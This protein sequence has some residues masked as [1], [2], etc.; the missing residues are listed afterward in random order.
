MSTRIGDWLNENTPGFDDPKKPENNRLLAKAET[1]YREEYFQ[2][3]VFWMHDIG[4]KQ[5]EETKLPGILS[6]TIAG[7][8]WEAY[9]NFRN[10]KTF[11]SVTGGIGVAATAVGFDPFGFVGDQI[12]G[13]ML[14]HVE[15]YRKQL[16]GLAGN[17]KMVQA[18]SDT[19]KKVAE[20]LTGM[21]TTWKSGVEADIATWT[22]S[23]GEAYRNR[24]TDL[25]DQI[26]GAG[27]IA[28]TLGEIMETVSKIV[29]AFRKM[30]QDI[31][32]SLAGALIGYTIELALSMGA[33]GPHVAAAVMLRIGRDGLKI[34]KLLYDMLAAFKD[35]NTLAQAVTAVLHALLGKENQPAQA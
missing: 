2:E 23:A 22:G 26:S 16:D 13:W 25:I 19:W 15:P 4:L 17:D 32:T 29:K 30:V 34:S 21:S 11:E 35:V 8:A 12:A 27:G 31:L 1:D 5:D 3:T 24:A 10:G 33:A 18:Y 20:E 9:A 28:A 7:D 6:G 14:T